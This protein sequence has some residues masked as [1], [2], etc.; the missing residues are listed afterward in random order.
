MQ[1]NRALHLPDGHRFRRVKAAHKSKI[2]ALSVG[3]KQEVTVAVRALLNLKLNV[4]IKLVLCIHMCT[5]C[6]TRPNRVR[7]DVSY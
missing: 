2:I 3:H 6:D 5:E 4:C 1:D 7:V